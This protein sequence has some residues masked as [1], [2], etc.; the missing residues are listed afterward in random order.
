MSRYLTYAMNNSSALILL[1]IAMERYR[2][3]CTPHKPKISNTCILRTCILLIIIGSMLA[4]PALWIYGIQTDAW[5]RGEIIPV[6]HNFA[7]K[8]NNTIIQLYQSSSIIGS[9]PITHA[10]NQSNKDIQIET[11]RCLF[12]DS[13]RQT[14]F[15]YSHLGLVT[16]ATELI[17]LILIAMY[18]QIGRKI[19]G[20]RNSNVL[21]A[22]A[23]RMRSSTKRKKQATL[24]LFLITLAFEFTFLPFIIITNIRFFKGPAWYNNQSRGGKMAYHFFLRSYY[25]NNAVNPFIYCIG[26]SNFRSALHKLVL[27]LKHRVTACCHRT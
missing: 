5:Y 21:S 10:S 9:I 8:H 4:L 12:D 13:F 24:V 6:V 2:T 7:H 11:K 23:E 25:F 26:S 17:L 20:L 19:V 22:D 1:A 16:I 3:I 27:A 15:A 18:V 14:W